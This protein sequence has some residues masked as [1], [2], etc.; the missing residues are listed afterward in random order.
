[1]DTLLA[2]PPATRIHPGHSDPTTVEGELEHNPFVRIWRGA[3]PEGE[4]P[5][6][7]LGQP[8]TLILLATDYDGGHK[9][10][11]RWEDGSDDIVP[12][13]KVETDNGGAAGTGDGGE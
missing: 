12:G 7:A 11:V 10:W 5:C 2:L 6:L 1:M 3:D 13:S 4:Q 9:A 8:A